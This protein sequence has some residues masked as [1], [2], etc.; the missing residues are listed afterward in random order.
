VL[1]GVSVAVAA[2]WLYTGYRNFDESVADANGRFPDEARAV[3]AGGG[4]PLHDPQLTL[5]YVRDS[6]SDGLGFTVVRT[7]PAG[8]ETSTLSIG[9]SV[10]VPSPTG[11]PVELRLAGRSGGALAVVAGVGHIVGR[12]VS[13]VI[14]LDLA[15]VRGLLDRIGGVPVDNPAP[16]RSRLGHRTFPAGRTVIRG[17]DFEAYASG[18]DFALSSANQRRLMRAI[19]ARLAQ[20][21]TVMDL[22][23]IATALGRPL[24]TDLSTSDLVKLGYVQARATGGVE[25]HIEADAATATIEGFRSTSPAAAGCDASR[26]ASIGPVP[27]LGELRAGAIALAVLPAAAL[28]IVLFVLARL[29][30]RG[31][32]QLARRPATVAGVGAAV[33]AA[34]REPRRR[35]RVRPRVPR[36]AARRR[37]HPRVPGWR[38]ASDRLADLAA[39]IGERRDR[40]LHARRE[41][42]FS[43]VTDAFGELGDRGRDAGSAVRGAVTRATRG[44]NDRVLDA[45]D[46][47]VDRRSRRRYRR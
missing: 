41:P 34:P 21:S 43:R 26:L 40:R 32:R 30:A 3:L 8:R 11:Q 18:D 19:T 45:W 28:L 9:S 4:D 23:G 6:A 16:F 10:R 46:A 14:A 33:A 37:V 42:R 27:T 39:G 7:D 31:V 2:A 29:A 15:G 44:A 20:A 1:L 17:D 35:A 24:T 13:H 25:C 36:M 38:R 22:P 12:P 5:V 47:V